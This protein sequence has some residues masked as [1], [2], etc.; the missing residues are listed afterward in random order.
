MLSPFHKFGPAF[1]VWTL[2]ALVLASCGSK[3]S[4]PASSGGL[5]AKARESHERMIRA[6]AKVATEDKQKNPYYSDWRVRRLETA[7]SRMSA[8]APAQEVAPLL[9]SLG[10]A[11]LDYGAI[12]EGI[13]NLE[14][15]YETYAG[16]PEPGRTLG[17][18]AFALG[19]ANLRLAE[20]ENCCSNHTPGSCILPLQGDAIHKIRRGSE[21][22]IKYFS[23][24]VSMEKM[25]ERAKR[26]STWLLNLA[27]MTLGEYPHKVP[28]SIRLPEKIFKSRIAVPRLPNVAAEL[29]VDTDSMSGGV[30][31]DDF[32]GDNDLDLVV[33]SWDASVPMKYF[34]NRGKDG[35]HDRSKS[36]GFEGIFGG[37]NMITADYDNDGDLD[38]YVPRG[39]WLWELGKRPNSL[40]QNQGDGTFLDVT[41]LVG[42]GEEHYPSQTAAWADYDNDGDL[43]LFVGNEHA[44]GDLEL[45]GGIEGTDSNIAPC[46][47]FRN[48]G[49]GTFIDVADEAGVTNMR[50]TKGCTWA[51]VDGDRWPDLIISNLSG[52]NRL[53]QNQQDGTFFDIAAQAGIQ[54]PYASFPV[55]TWDFDNDGVLD[56]FI[57]SFRGSTDAYLMYALGQKYPMPSGHYRGNGDGTFANVAVEQGLDMPMLTMGANFGDINNDGY[58]DFYI[59]TGQPDIAILVP[60]QLFLNQHGKRFHDI[61]MGSGLGHLQKGHA[62]AFADLDHDGDQDIF[63]QMGGAKRVD[64]YRDALYANRGGTQNRWIKI[65]LI[66]TQSNRSAVGARIKVT[67]VEN[68]KERSIY[69]HVNTGASFGANPLRQHIGIGTADEVAE[70]EVFW[71]TS[72]TTQV[73]KSLSAGQLVEITEGA[74]STKSIALEPFPFTEN[75]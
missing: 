40:L 66:G 71:P 42:L 62:I 48:N 1:V 20:T 70:V 22:A 64:H 74:D 31:V 60:N 44:E 2:A 18:I 27:Y 54:D 11:Q 15:A 12:E 35:F 25:P 63:E 37:L 14:K 65:K 51:D 56:I 67:I 8:S 45:E 58:L 5:Q 13:A 34:E 75:L 16:E 61:T 28:P 38:I 19:V 36:A 49:D 55:W 7:A 50:F 68:G 73:F 6:L 43:D 46:Q 23:Q 53:Y 33:S 69:R 3:E 47:L 4:E 57:S 72:D 32:D 21:A 52:E 10:L 26:K 39:A 17:E 41:Y 9:A 59:G 29:G 24:V 30:A